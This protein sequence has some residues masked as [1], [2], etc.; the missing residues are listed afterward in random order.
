MIIPREG[1]TILLV[2]PES[3]TYA[4]E[5]SKV[6]KVK[7]LLCYRE[8]AEPDYPDLE[9]PSSEDFIYEATQKKEIKKIGVAG[10]SILTLSVCNALKEA[11]PMVEIVRSD[12]LTR[13]RMIKSSS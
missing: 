2:R 4:K 10:Y 5:R 9:L 1:D 13:M 8:S 11:G 6:K 12:I 7:T 3:E